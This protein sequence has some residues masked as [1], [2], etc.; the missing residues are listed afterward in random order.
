[1]TLGGHVGVDKAL[2]NVIGTGD[3][4]IVEVGKKLIIPTAAAVAL[5]NQIGGA[6]VL[7]CPCSDGR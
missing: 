1:M 4:V 3:K 6:H 5:E 2:A 7:L